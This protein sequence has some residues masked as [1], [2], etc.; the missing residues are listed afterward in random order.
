MDHV[1]LIFTKPHMCRNHSPN[2][3][4]YSNPSH[5]FDS[6]LIM[7]II[8]NNL[9]SISKIID[10]ICFVYMGVYKFGVF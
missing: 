5:F 7:V 10:L 8:S 6:S 1:H 9:V 3:L 4:H 2:L